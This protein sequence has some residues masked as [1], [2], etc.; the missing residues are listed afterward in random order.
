MQVSK[1]RIH[2]H[3]FNFPCSSGFA[4]IIHC[5][6][7]FVSNAKFPFYCC[8]SL[9]HCV[10]SQGWDPQ[11]KWT[12]VMQWHPRQDILEAG[13]IPQQA[14]SAPLNYPKITIVSPINNLLFSFS[15]NAVCVFTLHI[16]RCIFTSN[17]IVCG[18]ECI[19]TVHHMARERHLCLSHMYFNQLIY[20]QGWHLLCSTEL[21]EIM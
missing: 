9:L 14:N 1:S 7:Y 11:M 2:I 16:P 18:M 17:H 4:L 8:F 21:I 10:E 6:W 12:A 15:E 19:F 20:T 13:W 5:V 3:Y